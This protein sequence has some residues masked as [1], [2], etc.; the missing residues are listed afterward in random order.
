MKLTEFTSNT[1][2]LILING[3]GSIKDGK[4]P[5]NRAEVKE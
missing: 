3:S 2:L 5:D 4:E 1:S